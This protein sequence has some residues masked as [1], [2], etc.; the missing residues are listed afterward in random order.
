VPVSARRGRVL[1]VDDDASVTRL[2]SLSL[3]DEGFEVVTAAN[4]EEALLAVDENDP[5]V[6]VLDLQMPVMDG[7]TFYRHLRE[8]GVRT[9]V[10]VLSAYGA[11]SASRR[12]GAEDALDKPF[13]P[14]LL[15]RRVSRLV[16]SL[17]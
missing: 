12:M 17:G 4:G 7:E 1:V 11:R 2:V 3:L 15:A 6:I 13:D 16:D 9:P 14:D 10:L 5:D 8:R